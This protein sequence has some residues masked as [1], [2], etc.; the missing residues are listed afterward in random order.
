MNETSRTTGYLTHQSQDTSDLRHFGPKN[1][2]ETPRTQC[3]LKDTLITG[4]LRPMT[5]I[6]RKKVKK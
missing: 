4:T 3:Q 2:Q 6:I 1:M 5:A